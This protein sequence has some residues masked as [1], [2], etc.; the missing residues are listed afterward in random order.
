MEVFYITNE[1]KFK[2]MIISWE[3]QSIGRFLSLVSKDFKNLHWLNE[4]TFF[5]APA[6]DFDKGIKHYILKILL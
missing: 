2:Y 5:Q 3:T 4:S 1:A 6:S